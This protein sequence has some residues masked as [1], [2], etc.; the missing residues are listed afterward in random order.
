MSKE[1]VLDPILAG[2]G[3]IK[4]PGDFPKEEVKKIATQFL[5]TGVSW[6]EFV[7][8]SPETREAFAEAS[9][10]L[11]QSRIGGL[12]QGILS[13]ED[14][15]R[16]LGAFGIPGSTPPPD[17]ALDKIENFSRRKI[18]DDKRISSKGNGA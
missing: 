8:M 6:Q 14:L 2:L 9:D 17:S 11:F 5:K 1:R 15:T 4:M 12:F 3:A 10:D 18:T 13:A 7:S 16:E